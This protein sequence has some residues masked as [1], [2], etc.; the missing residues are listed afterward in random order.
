MTTTISEVMQP[1]ATLLQASAWPAVAPYV[2]RRFHREIAG[3]IDGVARVKVAG[4][5]VEIQRE[6]PSA[7]VVKDEDRRKLQ[8]VDAG[9]FYTPKGLEHLIT[10]GKLLQSSEKIL[11]P[12]LLFQTMTQQTWLVPTTKRVFCVLDDERT[13]ASG[14]LIQWDIPLSEARS[15]RAYATER[16]NTVVDVGDRKRWLYSVRLHPS[17]KELEERLANIVAKAASPQ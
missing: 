3:V 17:P 1:I 14:R 15:V 16:G 13:R 4:A 2:V 12:F 8:L 7:S 6:K 10:D 9:G 5:E 11:E